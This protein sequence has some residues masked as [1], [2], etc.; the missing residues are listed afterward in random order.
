MDLIS[1]GRFS[2]H[3]PHDLSLALCCC[4]CLGRGRG[5]GR[6]S[7][8][9]SSGHENRFVL[10]DSY[11]DDSAAADGGGSYLGDGPDG[12][13]AADIGRGCR[14]GDQES[15][16]ESDLSVHND[17]Y[18]AGCCG[19]YFDLRCGACGGRCLGYCPRASAGS[20]AQRRRE[21]IVPRG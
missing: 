17:Y 12:A 4:L 3:Q 9:G 15:E 20:S 11:R 8:V 14:G 10:V 18:D 2:S 5:L 21:D 13:V 1:S 6:R 7:A 19:C 16:T